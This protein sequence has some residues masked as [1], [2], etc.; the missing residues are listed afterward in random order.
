MTMTTAKSTEPTRFAQ[1]R[2]A[3]QAVWNHYGL[4]LTENLVPVRSGGV[5]R[6]H[7]TGSGD[8]IL[9]VHGSGGS[10]AYW[11]PLVQYL[12]SHFRCILMDRPGWTLSSPIDYSNGSFGTIAASMQA[13]LLDALRV[14]RA[15][16]VGGS[17]GD[18][19]ALRFAQAHPDRV[20]GIVLAGGGPLT[21][22]IDPP[23]F[24]KLLRSP[25]GQIIIRIPQ[26]PGM[27]RKQM[28]GLGHKTSLSE[29]LIP[30]VL[31]ELYSS[32]SRDTEAMRHERDLV[33]NILDRG[34]WVNGFTLGTDEL[35]RITVPTLMVYGRDDPVGS[36]ETWERFAETLRNGVLYAIAD[37]GHLN[38]YDKPQEIATQITTHLENIHL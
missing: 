7:E 26:T 9:F 12:A 1:F 15:H 25:L 38:W 37:S 31:V 21:D 29:G 32:A 5:I 14:D 2:K 19:F 27:V 24:I 4:Q 36:V 16:L 20:G 30:D 23:T 28:E 18:L 3:E 17:I 8:P 10:G 33:R 35:R 11:A 34:G 13:D 22:A 6:V